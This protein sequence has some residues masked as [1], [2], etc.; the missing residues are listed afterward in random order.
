MGISS[1]IDLVVVQSDVQQ[2]LGCVIF[3]WYFCLLT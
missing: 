1:D 2:G 3:L